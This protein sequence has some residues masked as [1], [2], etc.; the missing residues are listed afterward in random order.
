[1]ENKATLK[2]IKR[3]MT[4]LRGLQQELSAYGQSISDSDFTNTMLTSLPDLWSTFITGV[5][6]GGIAVSSNAQDLR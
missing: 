1:M 4:Q 2:A 5:N 6:A 3:G